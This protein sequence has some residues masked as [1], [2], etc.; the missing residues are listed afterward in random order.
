[1]SANTLIN[2]KSWSTATADQ[3]ADASK[4]GYILIRTDGDP[5]R[6]TQKTELQSLGVQIHEFLGGG[7]CYGGD[8]EDY[9][10]IYLCGYPKG[11]SLD[12]IRALGYIDYVDVY[13]SDLVIHDA[14][15]R[16]RAR[17][18][19]H[20]ANTNGPLRPDAPDNL[21]VNYSDILSSRTA[22]TF[23]STQEMIDPLHGVSRDRTVEVDV[24]LHHDIS[25]ETQHELIEKICNIEGLK[26]VTIDEESGIIR[27]NVEEGVLKSIADLDEVRVIHPVNERVLMA[28]VTRRLLGFPV[29]DTS[30]TTNRDESTLPLSTPPTSVL[31]SS[32]SSCRYQGRDQ[33]VCVADT[34]FDKGS[35]T[36]VHRDFTGRVKA[37]HS[38]GRKGSS[39]DPDGHG[40]HVCG[41]VLGRGRHSVEGEV[42]GTAPAASLMLQSFFV[43]FNWQ[44]N[45]VLGGYPSDLGRLFAQAYEAGA[46]VHSNSWGTPPSEK[47]NF[48]QRPYDAS[49]ESIDRFIWDH[50]DMTVHFAA[51]N[52]G[53]DSNLDGRVNERSLGAEA[54]A[55]NCITVG[56]SENLRPTLTSGK[57]G[58]P[59]TYGFFWPSKFPRNPLKDDHQADNPD[60]LAAFS[61]RGPTA[62]NRLKPD[63]V[64][65]GTAILSTR[66][67]NMKLVSDVDRAGVS[68]DDS[69]RYLSGTSM[70]TP[71]VAGC[72]AVVREALL[73]NGYRDVKTV[74]SSG[75]R[76][77]DSAASVITNPTGALIRAL[78]ING[79]VTIKGQYVSSDLGDGPNPHSGFTTKGRVNVTETLAMIEPKTPG[80]G[81]YGVGFI[82]EETEEPFAV[83]IQVPGLASLGTAMGGGRGGSNGNTNGGSSNESQDSLTFK[84]TMTYADLPGAALAND[85]NLV[86]L[87]GDGTMQR[88][89]N[90]GDQEFP[91]GSQ[92]PFDRRN[93]VEQVVWPYITG[94]SVQVLVQPYRMMLTDVPFAY[95]WSFSRG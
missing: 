92:R 78:L 29:L 65:P 38:W 61:S 70:A 20:R 86:V 59:Y 34:G 93:N 27:L 84:V 72:C 66:S 10:Q 53:Q 47:D 55:K 24:L 2:G 17:P 18:V 60:G 87:S 13:S 31:F 62:E 48:K 81:G 58:A 57:K 35:T 22:P 52:D 94:D 14:V 73:A 71:Q 79:A 43:K 41:C 9:Q 69:Y 7:G 46:R 95:A 42:S 28:N 6:K 51:G 82:K 4:S 67:R 37:L 25:G 44:W 63:V 1:M 76:D 54:S 19:V 90:Q 88:H 77:D 85:L 83:R 11:H 33:L 49:A 64:A 50:Q 8:D 30:S 26:N 12:S 74:A 32:S 16:L 21:V 36:D 80:M 5:L 75:N 39:D 23:R 68:G 40:T 89:G 56:A 91:A 45:S 3:Q 15:E